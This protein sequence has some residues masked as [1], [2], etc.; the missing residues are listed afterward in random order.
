MFVFVAS[1]Y[2]S[3][4]ASAQG[5]G[6][7]GKKGLKALQAQIEEE[8]A[9]RETADTELL[10]QVTTIIQDTPGPQGEQ[11]IQGV[12]GGTGATGLAGADGVDGAPGLPG[13]DGATGDK[14]DTGTTGAQGLKGDTGDTG[15]VGATGAKGDKGDTGAKGAQGIQGETGATG[16]KGDKGDTGA[17]GE[18]GD[19]G[20]TG[21]TGAKGD[22][23]NTGAVG[24]TGARGLK[25]D[26][27][28]AGAKGD[29]GDTG[30][31]GTTGAKGDKGNIGATGA[32]GDIGAVGATGAD[33]TDGVDGAD[34]LDCATLLDHPWLKYGSVTYYNG[35][36]VGIG[37]D[38]PKGKLD[39]RGTIKLGYE[40][41]GAHL[42]DKYVPHHT[43]GYDGKIGLSY[44]N[45]YSG[46]FVNHVLGGYR[47]G[48][49]MT[50]EYISFRTHEGGYYSGESMRIAPG[51]NV[52]IGTMDTDRRLNVGFSDSSGNGL[53]LTNTSLGGR[54]WGLTVASND[55][56][57]NVTAGSLYLRDDSVGGIKF[58]V[59]QGGPNG[60]G[61]NVGIGTPTPSYK[62]DVAGTIRGSNVS[63]SDAR[64]KEEV[65]TIEN[66]LEKVSSM[67]GVS[68]R[69]KDKVMGDN[70]EIGV[71]AQEVEKVVPEVV[72]EDNEGIK[73]VAYDKLVG[74]LIEAVKELKSDNDTIKE[75]NVSLKAKNS[76]LKKELLAIKDR[77][78]VIEQM[79][80]A[81]SIDLPKEK[82]VSLPLK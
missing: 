30:A 64:L 9:A 33:G 8:T 55:N 80:L 78:S 20:A 74:V 38:D 13:A 21:T 6:K 18:K 73:S 4:I 67:R 5:K 25:G 32:K 62:L 14:G 77:Q 57:D 22:K 59:T 28:A 49:S 71:I 66:A 7:K 10:Q 75:D 37:T 12:K 70:M 34:G 40:S 63:P 36:N 19:T 81:L 45:G 23:G 72:S 26:T 31:T 2:V 43:P 16:A 50:N 68:F 61:G 82:L 58:V 46:V 54:M 17:K 11:G 41:S 29:K 51:G 60:T 48:S 3:S 35:G 65:R 69:W 53:R 44:I 39:V 42:I 24:A 52:S 47:G 56:V 76:Q 79:L 1:L 27:G 15:A